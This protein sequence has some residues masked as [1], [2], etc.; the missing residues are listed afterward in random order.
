MRHAV[1]M[2]SRDRP[3]RRVIVNIFGRKTPIELDD[4]DPPSSGV[5][6]VPGPSSGDDSGM[7]QASDS[8]DSEP[9]REP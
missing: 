2:P 4:E 3:M 5:R 9:T 6:Q 7:S 8:E 1:A